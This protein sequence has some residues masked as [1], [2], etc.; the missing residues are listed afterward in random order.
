MDMA[1]ISYIIVEGLDSFG[2]FTNF[3]AALRQC[4]ELGYAGVPG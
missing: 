4:K 2:S 3:T 1:N